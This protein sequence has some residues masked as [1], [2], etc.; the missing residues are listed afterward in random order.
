VK[1][2]PKMRE[3]KGEF[4]CARPG[5]DKVLGEGAINNH[6]PFCSTHC[7]HEYHGVPIQMPGR[8]QFV[9]STV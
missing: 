4:V 8:G 5:C 7:C 1:A 2:D 6:D 3:V 9:A